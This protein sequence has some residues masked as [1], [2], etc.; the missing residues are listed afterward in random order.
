MMESGSSDRNELVKESSR[1]DN[2]LYL[3]LLVAAVCFALAA[4]VIAIVSLSQQNGSSSP[5]VVNVGTGLTSDSDREDDKVWLIHTAYSRSNVIYINEE[6]GQVA[7]F[8]PDIVNAGCRIANKNCAFVFDLWSNCW[9]S[10]LGQEPR[11]GLGLMS[12]WFD[13]CTMRIKPERQRTF[14]F[15]D[16]YTKPPYQAFAVLKGNPGNFNWRDITGKKIGFIDGTSGSEQC[17][18]NAADEVVGAVVPTENVVHC[19]HVDDCFAKLADGTID[20]MFSD[21]NWIRGKDPV[22]EVTNNFQACQVDGF[23]MMTRK[24]SKLHE[25]WAP[26]LEKLMA[27][28]E[29]HEIC[30]DVRITHGHRPGYDPIDFCIGL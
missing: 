18:A 20:A 4:F 22:D 26:A 15:G 17:L 21:A 16:P 5:S 7:G 24:D 30:D 12:G 19:S 29:Y 1:R 6:T 8:I 28:K 13:A 2:T 11:G 14:A 3:V 25:W 9:D 10:Q 27:S 23:N